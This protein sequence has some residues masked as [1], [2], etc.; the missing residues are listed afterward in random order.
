M[1]LRVEVEKLN[2][3]DS[4][5]E[6]EF[7]LVPRE[8]F[9]NELIHSN[10]D[11]CELEYTGKKYSD[12]EHNFYYNLSLDFDKDRLLFKKVS[13]REFLNNLDA[14]CSHCAE[15]TFAVKEE[16]FPKGYTFLGFLLSAIKIKLDRLQP[17][18]SFTPEKD[19]DVLT[20]GVPNL[21]LSSFKDLNYIHEAY[22]K[23]V[24]LD[25]F[26]L[27]SEENINVFKKKIS[28]FLYPNFEV[29]SDF[30]EKFVIFDSTSVASSTMN[31]LLTLDVNAKLLSKI[32]FRPGFTHEQFAV[33]PYLEFKA[34]QKI[35]SHVSSVSGVICDEPTFEILDTMKKL[36]DENNNS[37]SNYETLYSVAK[38]V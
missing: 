36:F 5:L 2:L 9:Q 20:W 6:E 24:S 38:H 19:W 34:L 3:P 30:D 29:K 16:I 28:S 22:Q 7:L 11:D 14:F 27:N 23:R 1:S 8:G 35:V 17:G 13:L 32:L 10:F 15:L 21:F 12:A 37:M 18:V 25:N 26:G 31:Y 33:L 4:F